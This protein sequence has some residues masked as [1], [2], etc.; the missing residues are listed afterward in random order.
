MPNQQYNRLGILVQVSQRLHEW[1][2]SSEQANE[3]IE[4]NHVL[5]AELKEMDSLLQQQGNGSYTEKEQN[6]VAA[7]IEGQQSLLAVIKKDRQAVLS[8]MKQMNQKNKVVDNYY[9]SFQQPIFVDR[10]M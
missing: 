6:Q 8:K 10:G 1:D 7:I 9:S 5:L 2:G 4:K 3:I